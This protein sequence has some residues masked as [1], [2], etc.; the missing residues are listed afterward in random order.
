[1]TQGVILFCSFF[2][3]S[4]H[5]RRCVVLESTAVDKNCWDHS[6]EPPGEIISWPDPRC[7]EYREMLGQTLKRLLSSHSQ[8]SQSF[9]GYRF[10]QVEKSEKAR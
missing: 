5:H 8:R 6:R 10:F 7:D 4:C 9:G 1:M 3:K 2:R